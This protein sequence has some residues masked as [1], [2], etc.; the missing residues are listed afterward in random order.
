MYTTFR[1]IT[2]ASIKATLSKNNTSALAL[3]MFYYTRA[4]NTK[5]YF[6]LLSCFIYNIIKDYVCIDPLA[7]QSKQFG[8]ITVGSKKGSKHGENILTEY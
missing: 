4:D 1:E 5:K 8:E 7:C 6:R 2:Q 3:I